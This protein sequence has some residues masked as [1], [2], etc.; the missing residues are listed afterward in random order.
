MCANA[1]ARLYPVRTAATNCGLA[2]VNSVK[3]V[4]CTRS[5]Y[6]CRPAAVNRTIRATT[7]SHTSICTS[8]TGVA[9]NLRMPLVKFRLV[10]W[11]RTPT[12]VACRR[13]FHADGTNDRSV[14]AHQR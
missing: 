5:V 9:F 6:D 1:N 14:Y 7:I 13:P 11:P 10:H 3:M 2:A 4:F 8:F 12:V